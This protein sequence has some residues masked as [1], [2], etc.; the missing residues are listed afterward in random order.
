MKSAQHKRAKMSRKSKEVSKPLGSDTHKKEAFF[1]E[2]VGTSIPL[3]YCRRFQSSRH[4][5]SK[6][7]KSLAASMIKECYNGKFRVLAVKRGRY[8]YM[9]DGNHRLEAQKIHAKIF[10]GGKYIDQIP[11]YVVKQKDINKVSEVYFQGKQ[12]WRHCWLDRYI[13]LPDGRTY[14]ES[15]L[16]QSHKKRVWK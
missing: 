9:L 11:A 8:Y 10:L 14:G 2:A 13:R 1:A 5:D 6:W 4:M 15:K 16:R 12:P 7:I 3:K